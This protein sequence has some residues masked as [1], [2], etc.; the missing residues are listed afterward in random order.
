M[1]MT[2]KTKI[3]LFIAAAII[4]AVVAAILA[5]RNK[6]PVYEW[7][8]V[9][10]GS[11][12][13]KVSASGQTTPAKKI[14]LQ[15]EIQG[16][17]KSIM[18]EAGEQ[19]KGGDILAA[20]E[21]S[22]LRSQT[23]EYQAALSVAQASL[24]KL[25][26]GSSPE[27]IA[28]YETALE[29]AKTTLKNEQQDLADAQAQAQNDL[30]ETYDDGLDSVSAAYTAG[31]KALKTYDSFRERYF[32]FNDT[33][34]SQ[35]KLRGIATQAELDKAKTAIDAANVSLS[36]NNVSVALS[37]TKTALNAIK[38]ILALMRTD[39]ED[40]S[41]KTAV[42]SADRTILNT[43]RTTI[44]TAIAEATTARQKIS[45]QELANQ[46]SINAGQAAV[47]TA[48]VSVQSS[49]DKLN[50]LKAPARSADIDFNEAQVA[51]SMAALARAQ[52]QLAKTVLRAP[53]NGVVTDVGQK[54]GQTVTI[55]DPVL[56]I[57]TE[58]SLL[59]EIDISEVDIGKVKL[60]DKTEVSLD[61]FPDE[62]FAGKV[63]EISPSET[64]SQGVVYYK[65]KVGFDNFDGR[66]KPGMTAD[67]DIITETKDNVLLVPSLAVTRT[68]GEGVV[69]VLLDDKLTEV[70]VQ[71]GLR[72]DEGQMEIISGLKEGDKVVTFIKK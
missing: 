31:D 45:S 44:D 53:I 37:Q 18:V 54:A 63:I 48:K 11:I 33:I 60:S 70:K 64:I 39:M 28:V 6:K 56:S 15:F 66:P 32:Y 49:Q 40:A 55:Q 10:R 34:S 25:L 58:N 20:L 19:V 29:A 43:E 2:T 26:A 67:V 62:K 16:R 47:D 36:G 41:Y 71:T 50:Q 65:A 38:D 12:S 23:A 57:M 27:E 14:N 13:Q 1:N 52:K 72:D 61:A 46:T 42:L 68:D 4:V 8:A 7:V 69:K 5:V 30:L 3:I 21:D 51:Q 17:I 9:K 22:E 24:E 35:L 59:V